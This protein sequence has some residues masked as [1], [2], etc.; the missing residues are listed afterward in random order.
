MQ[1]VNYAVMA[2]CTASELLPKLGLIGNFINKEKPDLKALK[3]FFKEHDFFDKERFETLLRFL[4]VDFENEKQVKCGEFLSKLLKIID[5]E[6][7]KRHLFA[8][9]T[10]KNE[11]LMKYVMDG[12]AERLYS[13]NELYRYL[14]S[15]V[16]PGTYLTLVDFRYWMLW[17]EASEHIK[18]V[19]IRWGLSDLGKEAMDKIIKLIDV[20]DL[21]DE[22]DDDDD[23]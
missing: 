11:I 10:S 16:Y 6:D 15:Y 19:G 9:L 18:V 13:T 3:R 8:H 21:L 7:R 5:P 2:G 17:L 22:E 12:I 14:T 1:E 20:D 23:D 4:N